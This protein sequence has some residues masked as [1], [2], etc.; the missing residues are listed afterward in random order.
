[1]P[2]GAPGGSA[3]VLTQVASLGALRMVVRSSTGGP[4]DAVGEGG[5]WR[6]NVGEEF[7]NQVARGL[8]FE[9][10]EFLAE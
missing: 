9:V 1:M 3:D 5:R 8:R 6:V 2:D 7:V 4:G 10:G